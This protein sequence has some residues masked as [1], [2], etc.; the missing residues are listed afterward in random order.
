MHVS[1]LEKSCSI[2]S[3]PSMKTSSPAEAAGIGM[4]RIAAHKSAHCAK[5]LII[6]RDRM[7]CILARAEYPRSSITTRTAQS[8]STA[9]P[10]STLP[11]PESTH[12]SKTAAA[13]APT[14]PPL[15]PP[16]PAARQAHGAQAKRRSFGSL[17]GLRSRGRPR[18]WLEPCGDGSRGLRDRGPTQGPSPPR[19]RPRRRAA[20]ERASAQ[21]EPASVWSGLRLGWVV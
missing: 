10:I 18:P 20:S 9:P 16:A 13:H 1:F 11:T 17:G 19:P 21:G 12:G 4:L 6:H 14:H 5:A 8:S 2:F 15:Q 3:L 7:H